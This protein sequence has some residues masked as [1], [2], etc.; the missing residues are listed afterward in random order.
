[1]AG[2][3][4]ALIKILFPILFITLSTPALWA[5]RSVMLPDKIEEKILRIDAVF[6]DMDQFREAYDKKR[7]QILR[8]ARSFRMMAD[9][10]LEST[11]L[12]RYYTAKM[13]QAEAEMHLLDYT[14]FKNVS[15]SAER[16]VQLANTVINDVQDGDFGEAMIQNAL[17]DLEYNITN[18]RY[19]IKNLQIIQNYGD[20]TTR[21][22]RL[23]A[24]DADWHRDLIHHWFNEKQWYSD[25][26]QRLK[27]ERGNFSHMTDF[28]QSILGQSREFK[29]KADR[30]IAHIRSHVRELR[31]EA[32]Q[33]LG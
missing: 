7:E 28:A 1:M 12:H 13:Q 15:E 32:I 10:S 23:I 4:K 11:G 21:E 30:Q 5:Q 14:F 3:M 2:F 18:S 6:H 19:R 17:N 8:E 22:E 25:I 27:N 20:L 16:A 24:S 9:N 33:R 26:L 29:R 31:Q